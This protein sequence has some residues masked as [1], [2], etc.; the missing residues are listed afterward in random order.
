MIRYDVA[1]L[2]SRL[3]WQLQSAHVV[4]KRHL[5]AAWRVGSWAGSFPAATDLKD[6]Q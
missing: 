1:C 6:L 5:K 4:S 2:L 3:S